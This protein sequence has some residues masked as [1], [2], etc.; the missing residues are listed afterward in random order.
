MPWNPKQPLRL[1]MVRETGEQLIVWYSGRRASE[2]ERLSLPDSLLRSVIDQLQLRLDLQYYAIRR[3]GYR[4]GECLVEVSNREQEW[5]RSVIKQVK[6]T[7]LIN[8]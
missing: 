6:G 5:L 8:P 4:Q 2:L 1:W 7:G 3:P